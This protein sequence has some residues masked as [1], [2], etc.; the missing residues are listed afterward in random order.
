VQAA[1]IVIAHPDP[2]FREELSLHLQQHRWQ[3]ETRAEPRT[4]SHTDLL[5]APLELLTSKP[6]RVVALALIE[7]AGL[8]RN[9]F[10]HCN[11]FVRLPFEPLELQARMHRLLSANSKNS[12][13]MISIGEVRLDI[14]AQRVWFQDK[15]LGLTRREFELL[16]VLMRNAGRT[17]HKEELLR[18][19]WGADFMGKVRTV[20]QHVLQVRQHLQDHARDAKYLVTVHGRGYM[21][22]EEPRT[23]PR[24]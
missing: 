6:K 24:R 20:D 17:I 22:L 7:A 8:P 19:A 14:G 16:E 5:I 2:S 10:E 21:F 12:M 9:V 18:C 11:D 13:D 1:L 4:N 23:T 15:E 3:I